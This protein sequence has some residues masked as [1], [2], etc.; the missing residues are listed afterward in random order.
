MAMNI[1]QSSL[2]DFGLVVMARAVWY[3]RQRFDE[4]GG[5]VTFGWCHLASP[6][7]MSNMGCRR[8]W[9]CRCTSRSSRMNYRNLQAPKRRS[10]MRLEGFRADF[11]ST[12]FNGNGRGDVE[13]W[14]L[15]PHIPTSIHARSSIQNVTKFWT[16]S[17]LVWL[18]YID[19]PM[20]VLFVAES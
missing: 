15:V 2:D 6:N 5:E 16:K 14:C 3:R 4:E 18:I 9:G 13:T 8:G 11:V 19:L 1:L 17:Y 12:L 7:L 20:S 10:R